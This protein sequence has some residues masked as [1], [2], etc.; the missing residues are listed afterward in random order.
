MKRIGIMSIGAIAL[1]V[2]AL[3]GTGEASGAA[4]DFGRNSTW[5]AILFSDSHSIIEEDIG[6]GSLPETVIDDGSKAP[7][8]EPVGTGTMGVGSDQKL[9]WPSGYD[10]RPGIDGP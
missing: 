9:D 3:A 2:C 6:T 8:D 7:A 1:L 4:P 10:A 5:P